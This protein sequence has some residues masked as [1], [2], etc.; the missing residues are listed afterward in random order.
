[1]KASVKSSSIGDTS[2]KSPESGSGDD[3]GIEDDVV[4][5]E[6]TQAA[7]VDD[8]AEEDATANKSGAA[9]DTRESAGASKRTL[10]RI[11][12]RK[13]RLAMEITLRQIKFVVAAAVVVLAVLL[14][15][16]GYQYW[17]V[18]NNNQQVDQTQSDVGRVAADGAVAILSYKH[19]SIDQDL[20]RAQSLLTGEF[21]D[22]YKDFTAEVVSPAAKEKK[23]D[24]QATIAGTAVESAEADHAVALVFVNQSTTTI[25][26]VSPTLSASSVRVELKKVDGKWLIEKFDPV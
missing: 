12:S 9:D 22:Y 10:S 8:A 25:D 20:Q 16:A 14:G 18:Y 2:D 23:V 7:E 13:A 3:A 6:L 1:M 19:D 11:R 15:L 26:N 21:A 24:T 4:P 5:H 17:S